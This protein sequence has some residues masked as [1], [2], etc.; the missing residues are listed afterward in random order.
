MC[1]VPILL[2][3]KPILPLDTFNV[4]LWILC[5]GD[6]TDYDPDLDDS[7]PDDFGAGDSLSGSLSVVPFQHKLVYF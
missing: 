2:T 3:V 1:V 6:D 4:D 7:G 5:E